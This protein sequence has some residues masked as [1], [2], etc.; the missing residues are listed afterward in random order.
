[1]RQVHIRVDDELYNELDSYSEKNELS[2]QDC[3]R[4]AVA[5]YM[6]DVK[7][8]K[9]TGKEKKFTFIDLFAGIGGMR[10][11]FDGPAVNV[12]IRV[13]GT[14][15]VSRPISQILENSRKGILQKLMLQIFRIMTFWLPDF[16]VSLFQ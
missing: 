4:E 11:A 1:M 10:I 13:N 15:T 16:R 7:K 2:M 9:N 12:F 14:S 6:S 3:V 5:Y 8:K